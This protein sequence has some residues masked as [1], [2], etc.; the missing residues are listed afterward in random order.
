M[1]FGQPRPGHLPRRQDVLWLHTRC[2][3]RG[4]VAAES[5]QRCASEDAI[6][7]GRVLRMDQQWIGTISTL[8]GVLVAGGL[9]LVRDARAEKRQTTRDENQRLHEIDEARF[10]SR[11]DAYVGFAAACQTAINETDQYEYDHQGELPGDH[12][13]EG[14]IRRVISALDLVLIIGPREAADAALEAS[15]QLH[16]WAFSSGSRKR[17]VDAVDEFQALARRILKFDHL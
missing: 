3:C 15:T 11:K 2:A 4:Y 12:G 16:G 14:P 9:G 7:H 8:S 10:E 1:A 6:D 17:A 5:T 13:H